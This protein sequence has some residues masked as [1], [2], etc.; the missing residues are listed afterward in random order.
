MN[1]P[2]CYQE[3]HGSTKNILAKTETMYEMFRTE[4]YVEMPMSEG[5]QMR[6]LFDDADEEEKNDQRSTILSR[7]KA[8]ATP[9]KD[10]SLKKDNDSDYDPNEEEEGRHRKRRRRGGEG[11]GEGDTP[12]GLVQ[13]KQLPVASAGGKVEEIL[14]GMGLNVIQDHSKLIGDAEE[15]RRF[16]TMVRRV[17]DTLQRSY[18]ELFESNETAI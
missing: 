1:I 12:T 11:E 9:S 14:R 18:W 2:F 15:E 8:R 3:S 10:V 4:K 5:S 6:L 16:A 13:Q 17:S 7:E